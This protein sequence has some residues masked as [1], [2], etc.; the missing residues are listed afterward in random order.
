MAQ[1]QKYSL[2][3]QMGGINPDM[4]DR[5]F[6]NIELKSKWQFELAKAT[7]SNLFQGSLLHE[8]RHYIVL[9][10]R[11]FFFLKQIDV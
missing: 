4:M 8:T 7:K 9:E 2:Y 3:L 10:D 6:I 11:F 1:T 5:C